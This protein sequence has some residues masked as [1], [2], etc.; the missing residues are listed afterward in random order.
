MRPSRDGGLHAAAALDL[1][2]LR[3][4]RAGGVRLLRDPCVACA[5]RSLARGARAPACCRVARICALQ[6][7]EARLHLALLLRQALGLLVAQADCALRA[8]TGNAGRRLRRLRRQRGA[9]ILLGLALLLAQFARRS[10]RQL[11]EAVAARAWRWPRSSCSLARLSC[12]LARLAFSGDCLAGLHL[13]H[14]LADLARGLG[15]G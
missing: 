11:V 12:S 13:A 8:G 7:L 15:G 9:Q 3:A 10:R 14:G 4:S 5:T 1:A 2:A 6:F